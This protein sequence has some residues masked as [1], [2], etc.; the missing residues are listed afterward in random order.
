MTGDPRLQPLLDRLLESQATPEQVCASCPELL[1]ELRERWRQMRRVRD[2]L[3][4]LFPPATGADTIP[5]A[6]PRENAA[7]PRAPGYEL[8]G[9]LGRGGVGVVYRAR[10]LRLNRLVA[11]KMLLAGP[12]AGPGEQ[13]RFLR[14]AEAE[15]SLRHPNIVQLYDVGEVDGRPY[16]TMELVEGGSLASKLAGAPLPARQA[17]ALVAAVADG[18]Q[19]AH[20]AGIVHRD[21]KPANVL[22][23]ADDT[24]KVTDFGL[25]RRLEGGGGLTLSGAPVGTPSYMAPEQARGEMGAVGPAADVYALGAILYECLTGRPPFRAETAAA[26]LQQ[27]VADEP[28]TPARLN[29]RIPRDLETVCLKCLHND[30]Y[31]RYDSAAALAEDLRRFDRGEPIAARPASRLERAA[32]WARRRPAAAVL[33]ASGLLMIAG[34]TGAAVWY[35]GDRARLRYEDG[36]RSVEVQNRGREVNRAANDA[37][38][39]AEFHLKDLRARLDDPLRVRELLSDIDRWHLIVEQARQAWQRAQSARAGNEALVTDQAQAR[40]RTVETTLSGEYTGYLLARELDDLL[41][42]AFMSFDGRRSRFRTTKA[43]YA[44]FFSLLGVDVAQADKVRLGPVIASSPIRFALVAGLDNWA[45]FTALANAEDP[46]LGLL[47]ELARAAD[48]DPWRDRFRAPAAW[49]DR[50]ALIGLTREVDVERQSPT[51]LATLGRRLSKSGGDPAALYKQAVLCHP[52]DFWLHLHAAFNSGEPGLRVGLYLAAVAI[53]PRSPVA[54]SDLASIL[55]QQNDVQGALIAASQAIA[56]DSNFAPA[57]YA[58][59]SALSEQKDLPRAVSAFR[60]ASELDPDSVGA[61]LNLGKALGRQRDWAS[62]GAAYR[63]ATELAPLSGTAFQHLGEAL[64]EQKDLAGAVAAGNKATELDPT[65]AEAFNQFGQTLYRCGKRREAVAAFSKAVELN[66]RFAVAYSH[67]GNS[68]MALKDLPGAIAAFKKAIEL[69]PTF[70]S[71]HNN[72]GATLRESKEVPGAVAAYRKAI[73]LDPS[74]AAARSNL[75]DA[76]LRQGDW[77]GAVAAAQ[78]AIELDPQ[79]AAAYINLGIALGQNKDSPGA[80]AAFKRAIELDPELVQGHY[81]LG[82]TLQLRGQYAQAEQAYLGAVKAQPAFVPAHNALAWL[83]ATCPDDKVRD[84]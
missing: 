80:V 58:L 34:V 26:T 40:I 60:K 7:L 36:L 77:P 78:K 2:E 28:V 67:L 50:D 4:M 71:A 46:Q 45:D 54:Y 64:R 63:R 8:L 24:P 20:E 51:I 59:G 66:P 35:V 56:V 23:T 72:L 38:D 55:L 19:A 83:L 18:V 31:R 75:G 68:L 1:A 33:L 49:R 52:R 79:S 17:A 15:A 10:H 73:E 81:C 5:G 69:D 11:L 16:F 43:K 53:R 12:C 25:A 44:T 27:V 82:M 61:F 30:P 62:A 13:E 76:L 3:D 21:L 39:Q 41:A 29:P 70:A 9:E 57:Y 74:Y 48:P 14:E 65:S 32:K 47:L 22:L 37:L 84:G 6:H 42:E